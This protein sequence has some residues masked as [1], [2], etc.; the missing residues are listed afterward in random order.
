MDKVYS[1]IYG[2]ES[3]PTGEVLE[4][5]Q[6]EDGVFRVPPKEEPE[7]VQWKVQWKFMFTGSIRRT[8]DEEGKP[9]L[10]VTGI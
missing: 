6:G 1:W 5:V 3:K 4:A 7:E 9:F 2:E 10:N 8:R